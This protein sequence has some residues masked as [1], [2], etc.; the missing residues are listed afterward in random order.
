MLTD[1]KIQAKIAKNIISLNKRKRYFLIE[2]NCKLALY[3]T[4][5]CSLDSQ[6]KPWVAYHK[7]S[8]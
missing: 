8:L 5:A 7:N 1:F 2:V 6:H 4:L 3:Q